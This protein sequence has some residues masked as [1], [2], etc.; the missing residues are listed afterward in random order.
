MEEHTK[1]TPGFRYERKFIDENSSLTETEHKIK[2]NPA[3]FSEIY[4]SRFV[5]N[6]YL[7]TPDYRFYLD[8]VSGKSERK[9]IRVRWY[10][11]LFGEIYKPVLEFK[12]K[13][14]YLGRKLHF[15]LS[16]FSLNEDF[17]LQSLL[18]V[19]ERSE[20]PGWVIEE[21]TGLEPTLLNSYRRKYFLSF[22]KYFRITLDDRLKYTKIERNNNTF[23]E[24]SINNRDVVVELKYDENKDHMAFTVSNHFSFRLSRNS[25]YVNGVEMLTKNVIL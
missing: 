24:G 25:K 21:L 20:L 18:A 19:F 9:K 16:P 17:S 14:G 4:N 2:I 6:I 11:E 10:G 13:K 12:I 23:A 7:D 22:N 8:N 3:G 5:N 15:N 1:Q